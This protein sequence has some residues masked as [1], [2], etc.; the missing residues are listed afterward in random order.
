METG[1][2]PNSGAVSSGG[3]V[4]FGTV[5]SD[6]IELI[7]GALEEICAVLESAPY[8]IVRIRKPLF[9]LPCQSRSQILLTPYGACSTK[10]K[11]SGKDR[12]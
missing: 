11:G 10:T 7:S 8:L 9:L 3:G 2:L 6:H 1:L 12:F 5:S 4:T